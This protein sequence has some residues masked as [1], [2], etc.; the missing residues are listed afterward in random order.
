[1]ENRTRTAQTAEQLK[2]A[3]IALISD[4]LLTPLAAIRAGAELIQKFRDLG[5]QMVLVRQCVASILDSA[6]RLTSM[7]G[8]LLDISRIEDGSFPVA[9]RPI[10]LEDFV[11]DVLTRLAL[12]L[13]GRGLELAFEKGL[14]LAWADPGLLERVVKNLL[15]A[16]VKHSPV[17]SPILIRAVAAEP[18]IL[19]SVTD[20]GAGI[21]AEHLSTAFSHLRRPPAGGLGLCLY[22]TERAVS[23]LGGRIRVESEPGLGST[24]SF[25][26]PCPPAPRGK[27]QR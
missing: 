4:D 12:P 16:A 9:A 24:F 26:L 19:V 7:V 14:P 13:E 2:E 25:T 11:P 5:P 15:R 21:G 1:V 20:H 8:D 17:G 10:S 27:G 18:E 3:F 22:I 6:D 23:A